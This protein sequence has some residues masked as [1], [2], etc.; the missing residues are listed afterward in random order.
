M[1]AWIAF[2]VAAAFAQTLRFMVQKQLTGAGLSAGGA[3]FARFLYSAPVVLVLVLGYLAVRGLPAPSMTGAFWVYALVGGVAQVL[4]TMC[5]VALFAH[6]NF[7][8]GITFKKTEVILTAIVGLVVLGDRVSAPGWAALAVGLGGVL[9]LSDPPGSA[10][11]LHRRIVNRAAG[12]GLLSGVFFAISAVC[13]RGATLALGVED[14][15]L[16]AGWTL[17][18]VTASQLVGMALWLGWRERGEIGRVLRAWRKAGLVGLFSLLGSFCWFAAF[19]L[20]SA[21]YVFAVGQ[22]ELIFSLAVSVLVFRERVTGRELTGIA[23]LPSRSSLSRVSAEGAAAEAQEEALLVVVAEEGHRLGRAEVG[24]ASCDLGQHDLRDEG[25]VEGAD[26]VERDPLEEREFVGRAGEVVGVARKPR[27]IGHEEACVEPARTARRRDR[28]EDEG[29]RLGRG[30]VACRGEGRP[31]RRRVGPGPR[32]AEDEA[33]LLPEFADRARGERPGAGRWRAV[34]EEGGAA[35]GQG[36]GERD[37]RIGRIDRAAG[38]DEF[39]RHEGRARAALAHQHARAGPGVAQEDHGGGVADGIAHG[40]Q[41]APPKPCM[42][43][44][45]WKA[46][47]APLNRG[48]R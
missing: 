17:A 14:L 31:V 4:A 48:S 33:R 22:V 26:L 13:Y 43:L 39:R 16:R 12:L 34:L 7:A 24:Q 19:S 46:T 25:K 10:G 37:P 11:P 29:Q 38:K 15:V 3:T 32:A 36:C 44:A 8:V 5:T 9:L 28:A 21:A 35:R 23:L 2:S 6:R 47:I 42:R 41:A 27:G 1:D 30:E 20:Q 18:A 40:A 45:H